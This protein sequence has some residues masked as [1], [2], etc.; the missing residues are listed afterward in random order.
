MQIED[1]IKELAETFG[2][3]SE[4]GEDAKYEYIIDLGKK[5]P[6]MPEAEITE[7][8]KVRGC[9]SQVWL[10]HQID[11]GNPPT[12]RFNGTSDSTLVKGLI[13]LLLK[14]VSNRSPQEI[15]AVDLRATF[16]RLGI[17]NQISPNRR[18]GFVSMVERIR[19][20]AAAQA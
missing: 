18:N 9:I 8:N 4:M 17:E 6:P 19:Q 14:I 20:I 3:L 5:L 16:A 12:L 7:A 15:L 13:G 11:A 2:M 1:E 10:T